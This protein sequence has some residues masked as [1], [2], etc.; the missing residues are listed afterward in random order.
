[1]AH[2]LHEGPATGVFCE[3]VLMLRFHDGESLVDVQVKKHCGKFR[4]DVLSRIITVEHAYVLIQSFRLQ[5][6]S[7]S[8]DVKS[9]G[10]RSDE[11]TDLVF[12]LITVDDELLDGKFDIVFPLEEVPPFHSAGAVY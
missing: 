2:G 10:T 4:I 7:D 6:G 8:V 12:T 5:F 1:M 9:R 3:T 11:R